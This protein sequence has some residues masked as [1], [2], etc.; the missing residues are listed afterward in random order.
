MP[1]IIDMYKLLYAHW[2]LS[3][4]HKITK[5]GNQTSPFQAIVA[6]LLMHRF[7]CSIYN[8]NF[9]EWFREMFST[10]FRRQNHFINTIFQKIKFF[11]WLFSS[12]TYDITIVIDSMVLIIMVTFIWFNF[13]L[14]YVDCFSNGAISPWVCWVCSWQIDELEQFISIS[15]IIKA[16]RWHFLWKSIWNNNKTHK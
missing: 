16:K 2:A 4:Q 13:G 9:N 15:T 7:T 10:V 5:W 1:Y 11:I 3:H 8:E 12:L 6:Y 14:F